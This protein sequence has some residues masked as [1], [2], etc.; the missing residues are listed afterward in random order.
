MKFYVRRF[1]FAAVVSPLVPWVF[2]QTSSVLDFATQMNAT[3]KEAML[4][5]GW[6]AALVLG[7]AFVFIPKVSKPE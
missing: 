4:N 2:F 6:L 3:N 1:I 7:L 5:A